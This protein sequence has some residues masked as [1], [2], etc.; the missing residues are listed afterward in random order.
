ME[1]VIIVETCREKMATSSK[2]KE[3]DKNVEH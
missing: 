2:T 1:L 3:G